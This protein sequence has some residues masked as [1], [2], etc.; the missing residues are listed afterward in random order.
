GGRVEL[1]VTADARNAQADPA[2][3]PPVLAGR[4]RPAPRHVPGG[5]RTGLSRHAATGG[6][7]AGS[8]RDRPAVKGGPDTGPPFGV[9]RKLGIDKA[10]TEAEAQRNIVRPVRTQSGISSSPEGGGVHGPPPAPWAD[11]WLK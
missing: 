8:R 10:V 9:P 11:L 7:P 6:R 5:G 1:Y 4:V 2:K 3:H